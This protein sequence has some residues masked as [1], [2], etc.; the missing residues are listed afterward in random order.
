MLNVPAAHDQ[1]WKH[2]FPFKLC[3][4]VVIPYDCKTI[5]LNLL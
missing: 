4:V 5:G 2:A 3:Y 1:L